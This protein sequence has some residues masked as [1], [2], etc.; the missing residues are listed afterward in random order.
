MGWKE[1][2]AAVALRVA[3][4]SAPAMRNTGTMLT[5]LALIPLLEVA[6]LVTVAR[7][8]DVPGAATVAYA[9]FVVSALAM[10]VAQAVGAVV[11]DRGIGVVEETLAVSP[12]SA[13]Y[14]GGKF[15]FPSATALLTSALGC[16]AVWAVEPAHSAGHLGRALL[17]IALAVV[18]GCCVG[19][20]CSA[21]AI[22]GRDPFLAA[23]VLAALLPVTA[24][25]IAPFSAYPGWL[26]PVSAVLPGTWLVYWLRES[27]AGNP[28]A[29]PLLAEGLIAVAWVAFGV[30]GLRVAWARMR[31]GNGSGE[32]L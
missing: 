7:S 10:V 21:V 28:S 11:R 25:V 22:A 30:V 26:Q 18:V 32:V 13:A 8:L 12:W 29:W 24:G 17:G 31:S 2:P 5:T 1:S 19:L 15:L 20:A 9:G 4:V 23:N 16:V 14:W 27:I 3:R 6:L